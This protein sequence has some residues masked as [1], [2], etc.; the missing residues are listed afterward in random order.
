MGK[1]GATSSSAGWRRVRVIIL[2]L[3]CYP[4]FYVLAL[5]IASYKYTIQI[6]FLKK[7]LDSHNLKIYFC[8]FFSTGV[9]V[10]SQSIFLFFVL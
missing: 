8:A 9:Q 6:N 4:G 2:P 10:I 5:L 7:F 1:V 3:L